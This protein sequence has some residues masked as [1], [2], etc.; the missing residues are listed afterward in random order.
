[1]ASTMYMLHE[2]EKCGTIAICHKD[3]DG[4]WLCA[5]CSKEKESS[6]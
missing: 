2:C 6:E 4:P 1:M 5:E 3:D